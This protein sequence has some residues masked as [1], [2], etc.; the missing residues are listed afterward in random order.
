LRCKTLGEP[1]CIVI[2]WRAIHVS[3]TMNRKTLLGQQTL[4]LI[5]NM[6]IKAQIYNTSPL[7][8][9]YKMRKPG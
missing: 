2:P 7:V 6:T 4:G 9:L 1:R 3:I 5:S 8:N